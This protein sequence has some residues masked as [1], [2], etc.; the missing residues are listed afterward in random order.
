MPVDLNKKKML[1]ALKEQ[2]FLEGNDDIYK[3]VK[4]LEKR[5]DA[6]WD[7]VEWLRKGLLKI[8]NNRDDMNPITVK[9]QAQSVLDGEPTTADK[10]NNYHLEEEYEF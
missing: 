8:A 4:G 3:Q 9:Q 1:D 2:A 6:L 5:I 7:S 10:F